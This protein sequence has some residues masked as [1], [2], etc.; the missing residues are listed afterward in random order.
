MD[1]I[2]LLKKHKIHA[3]KLLMTFSLPHIGWE[4]D[5]QG[6]LVE[7]EGKPNQPEAYTT[8]HG[9]PEKMTRENLQSELDQTKKQAVTLQRVL[10]QLPK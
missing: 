5:N 10:D 4:T 6:W 7:L 2:Q 8:N 9:K 1:P 3:K